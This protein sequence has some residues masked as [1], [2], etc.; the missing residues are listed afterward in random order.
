[1]NYAGFGVRFAAMLVDAFVFVLV[2]VVTGVVTML[3]GGNWILPVILILLPLL[4]FTGIYVPVEYGATPGKLLLRL[5]LRMKN[6]GELTYSAIFLRFIVQCLVPV[7]MSAVSMPLVMWFIGPPEAMATMSVV[8]L[9]ILMAEADMLGHLPLIVWYGLSGLYMV[10]N[11]HARTLSDLAGGTVVEVL[12]IRK[13]EP[14]GLLHRGMSVVVVVMLLN[15]ASLPVNF[16]LGPLALSEITMMVINAAMITVYFLWDQLWLPLHYQ[17]TTGKWLLR[18]R[19]VRMD[20]EEMAIDTALVRM[21]PQLLL[22]IPVLVGPV[23]MLTGSEQ[24]QLMFWLAFIPPVFWLV[25]NVLLCLLNKDKRSLS[26][27]VA[28]TKAVLA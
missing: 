11:N 20:G 19:I 17:T 4:F 12:D 10:S 5:R 25:T 15:M 8:Q 22:L 2:I 18:V 7:L 6:G 16:F 27:L 28:G 24:S 1:M 13:G 23:A 26:D 9:H 3:S 14:A 21:L